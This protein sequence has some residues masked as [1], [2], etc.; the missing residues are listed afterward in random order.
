M[1]LNGGTTVETALVIGCVLMVILIAA[2][3]AVILALA[4][5]E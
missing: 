5:E 2:V 3:P 1:S 4:K